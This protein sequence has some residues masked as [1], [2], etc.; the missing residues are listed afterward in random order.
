MQPLLTPQDVA[1]LLGVSSSWVYSNKSR[2]GFITI[3][4][5]VRFDSDDVTRYALSRK[6]G[7]QHDE[8]RKW[9]SQSDTE[10]AATSGSSRKRTTVSDINA[11][12]KA[13]RKVSARPTSTQRHAKLQ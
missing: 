6:R 7:P 10:K 2:I 9:E 13:P 4:T 11:R 5:A 1:T 12:L 3:G 8:E